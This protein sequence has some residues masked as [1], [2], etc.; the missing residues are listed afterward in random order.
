MFVLLGLEKIMKGSN[1][2]NLT[3]VIME[4]LMKHGGL[5]YYEVASKL[6]LF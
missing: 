3:N 4:N 2:D 5:S 6:L 1:Y